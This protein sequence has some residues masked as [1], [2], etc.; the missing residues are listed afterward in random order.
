M[1]YTELEKE[2][3]TAKQDI[4]IFGPRQ[5]GMTTLLSNIHKSSDDTLLVVA[6]IRRLSGGSSR[7]A[8]TLSDLRTLSKDRV[9]FR[10]YVEDKVV[11]LDMFNVSMCTDVLESLVRYAKKVILGVTGRPLLQELD[12]VLDNDMY[13]RKLTDAFKHLD[14]WNSPLVTHNRRDYIGLFSGENE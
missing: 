9:K 14:A 2:L 4:F 5:C 11:I 1:K 8:T 3:T 6:H 7:D 10:K 12:V 13:V